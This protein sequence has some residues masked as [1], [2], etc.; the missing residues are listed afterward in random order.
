MQNARRETLFDLHALAYL[1][2]FTKFTDG[3][4]AV[5]LVRVSCV[6]GARRHKLTPH[7]H[8]TLTRD[9]A[10]LKASGLSSIVC[11]CACVLL[12]FKLFVCFGCA[13]LRCRT[14]RA[15]GQCGKCIS[16]L[17]GSGGGTAWLLDQRR[18][19]QQR[20]DQFVG[21]GIVGAG[22]CGLPVH[23]LQHGVLAWPEKTSL[24][25]RCIV[26]LNG[27]ELQPL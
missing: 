19:Q 13:A 23:Q 11:F 20:I 18:R 21:I 12:L 15:T 25:V 14:E 8:H 22:P 4:L 27:I 7:K 9:Y 24:S 10:P 16:V 26:G 3:V 17:V 5:Y 6:F 1:N 2:L